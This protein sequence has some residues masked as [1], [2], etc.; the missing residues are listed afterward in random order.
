M[1]VPNDKK[2]ESK[3]AEEEADERAKGDDKDFK[4]FGFVEQS[5]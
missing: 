5:S 3:D 2:G 1:V 4:I